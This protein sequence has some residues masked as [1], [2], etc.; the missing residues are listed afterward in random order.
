MIDSVDLRGVLLFFSH[1][2]LIEQFFDHSKIILDSLDMIHEILK[3][4]LG[5]LILGY[6]IFLIIC[7]FCDIFLDIFLTNFDIKLQ[8]IRISILEI[9]NDII[10]NCV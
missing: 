8:S 4:K 1:E 6:L 9:E 3:F 10:I 5:Y 2:I 7:L